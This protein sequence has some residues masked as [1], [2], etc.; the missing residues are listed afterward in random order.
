[1]GRQRSHS[2][3]L[4]NKKKRQL[5]RDLLTFLDVLS[6]Y[7]TVGYDLAYAWPE[8]SQML[9]QQG[10]LSLLSWEPKS[11][12]LHEWLQKL[13]ENFPVEGYRFI[14]ASLKQLYGRGAPLS[15]VVK[16]FSKYLRRELERDFER[17]LR[18]SPVRANACLMIFFLP[19][20]LALLFLPIL[21]YLKGLFIGF[22]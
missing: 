5:R 16:A 7:L 11:G 22:E 2:I 9:R 20:T 14:F 8:T 1:M 19:P 13:E 18:D 12:S 15:P 17:H 4:K 6:L 21:N 3:L 10:Y